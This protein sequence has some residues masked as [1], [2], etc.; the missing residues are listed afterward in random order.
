MKHLIPVPLKLLYHRFN[1]RKLEYGDKLHLG[2]GDHLLPGW[3]NVDFNGWRGVI[4]HNL[5]KPLPVKDGSVSF[6]FTE[7]FIEHIDLQEGLSFFK[8]CRRVLKPSGVLRVS[9]PDLKTLIS[10][11]EGDYRTEWM[12]DDWKTNCQMFNA[13]VRNWGHQFIYDYKEME[14]SL[15]E[16]G[17]NTICR[18]NRHESE[19]EEL[20]GLEKRPP[21]N[22]LIV[23]A[24]IQ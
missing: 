12:E 17:F 15:R 13:G 8:D 23:E 11:Y 1:N 19:Y 22:D 2:C 16:A 6:I 14:L 7:H 10:N 5:T 9:T 24:K 4:G 21:Q 3:S 18:V 20:R